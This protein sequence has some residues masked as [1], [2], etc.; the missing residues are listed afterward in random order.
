MRPRLPRALARSALLAALA[1]GGCFPP[2]VADKVNTREVAPFT[3]EWGPVRIDA[4]ASELNWRPSV[5]LAEDEQVTLRNEL[6]AALEEVFNGNRS[7]SANVTPARYRLTVNASDSN[8]LWAVVP[9]LVY[10][11][12]LGCPFSRDSAAVELDVQVGDQIYTARGTGSAFRGL[13]Y[14]SDYGTGVMLA[15]VSDAM[16]T[17]LRVLQQDVVAQGRRP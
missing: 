16:R 5:T 9:C 1:L 14:N 17:A 8:N 13:Y 6:A 10:F 4:R 15:A 2:A 12:V 11:V 7:T 3:R